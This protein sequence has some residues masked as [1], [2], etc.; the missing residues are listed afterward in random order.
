MHHE[1]HGYTNSV[2][3]RSSCSPL[4]CHIKRDKLSRRYAQKGY[5]GYAKHKGSLSPRDN[6]EN[7]KN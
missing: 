2:S 6:G 1:M 7:Q 5:T 4:K 3:G